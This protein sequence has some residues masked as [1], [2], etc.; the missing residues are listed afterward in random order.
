MQTILNAVTLKTPSN[1]SDSLKRSS[2]DT[3]IYV[4]SGKNKNAL[5]K[6][7]VKNSSDSSFEKDSLATIPMAEKTLFVVPYR[8]VLN[9]DSLKAE[10]RKIL[11]E[12]DTLPVGLKLIY[13]S[14]TEDTLVKPQGYSKSLFGSHLL[15]PQKME[16]QPIHAKNQNWMTLIVLL[17]LLLIGILRVFYQKKF[18]LFINAFISRRFSNQII[19][20]ENALTQSTSVLLTSI[21]FISLSLFF[22][23]C[24][25]YFHYSFIGNTDLSQY[26]F[27]LTGCIGFYILKLVANKFGGYIFKVIKETDEYIFNQFLVIQILGLLLTIWCI[28]LNYSTNIKKEYLIYLGIATLFIGFFVR[29]IKSFGISNISSYSPVY[30]F[31]Y[32]CSLEILPLII[33]VKLIIR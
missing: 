11:F 15:S 14:T 13:N 19:R 28:L 31:L 29:M 12:I 18:N 17:L 26:L 24:G 30:I 16:P 22:Y 25:R 5:I 3:G 7:E 9:R 20:E 32:L 4:G 2:V 23:L 1:N 33:I 10:A 8:C 6:A 21:F 27:I